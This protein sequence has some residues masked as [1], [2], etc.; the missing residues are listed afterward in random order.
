MKRLCVSK[1]FVDM[2]DELLALRLLLGFP[3]VDVGVEG[4]GDGR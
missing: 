2:G 1:A 3:S 4:L